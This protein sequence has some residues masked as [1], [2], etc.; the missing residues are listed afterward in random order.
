M[1]RYNPVSMS[2]IKTPCI[3][4]CST[5]SL[6]D[7]ICRGCKRFGFEVINWNQ[8]QDVEKRAVLNRIDQLTRQIMAPRFHIF[9]VDRLQQALDDYRFFY[10][11]QM[12]PHCWLHN[13]MQ[14]RHYQIRDLADLGVELT[15]QYAHMDLRDLL[16]EVNDELFQLS[17][18]HFER[19]FDTFHKGY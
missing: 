13:F 5:T 8:Y 15:P 11:P 2:T 18:A 12:S 7:K 1:A 17:L 16:G 3:G 6:G 14:K 4:I 9:S 10:D 19:Y